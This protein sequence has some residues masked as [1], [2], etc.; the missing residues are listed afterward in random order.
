MCE[1]YWALISPHI[2]FRLL[3]IVNTISLDSLFF[4]FVLFWYTL[5]MYGMEKCKVCQLFSTY[6]QSLKC[7]LKFPHP[8]TRSLIIRLYFVLH[9]VLEF[10]S[11]E[12]LPD[13][14][15]K[16]APIVYSSENKRLHC[17]PHTERG[18]TQRERDSPLMSITSNPMTNAH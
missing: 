6:D 9:S 3:S 13:L 10:V 16:Q 18:S 11:V 1:T 12:S 8:T 17:M 15:S 5:H 2:C 4:C 7:F 14:W